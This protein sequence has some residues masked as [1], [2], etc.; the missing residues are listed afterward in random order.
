M[1]RTPFLLGLVLLIGLVFIR[2]WDP[3]PIQAGRNFYFDSLQKIK[4]RP[5]QDVGVRVVDID[6]ASLR[7][8]GQWPWPRDVIADLVTQLQAYGAAI[9]VFDV[10]FAE[11][12]RYSPSNFLKRNALADL[13]LPDGARETLQQNPIIAKIRSNLV[14]RILN[15][16]EKMSKD[17]EED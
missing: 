7:K 5:F 16:L 15:L 2:V 11:A 13:S 12:D 4:P 8:L 1:G 17:Q 9:V 10:L 14:S 6:E 3:Y